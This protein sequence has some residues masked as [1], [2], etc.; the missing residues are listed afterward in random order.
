MNHRLLF[1]K[2]TYRNTF[3]DYAPIGSLHTSLYNQGMTTRLAL[4]LLAILAILSVF[5]FLPF[6]LPIAELD[7]MVDPKTLA[8]PDSQFLKTKGIDIHYK[9]FEVTSENAL[10]SD[11]NF[12]LIHDFATHTFSWREVTDD[13]AALGKTLAYDQPGQGLSD[14]PY[15][16]FP[17][18]NPYTPEA[19]VEILLD[20]LEASNIDKTYL[21][22]SSTGAQIALNTAFQHPDRVKGIIFAGASVYDAGAIRAPARVRPILFSPHM[23]LAGPIIMR[24]QSGD[25]GLNILKFSWAD[26]TK[27]TE[28][29]IAGHQLAQKTSRWN[30]GLWEVSRNSRPSNL[31]AEDL[32]KLDLPILVLSGDKDVVILPEISKQLASELGNGSY[33]ELENCGHL[34]FE[35]CSDASMNAVTTWLA[36]QSSN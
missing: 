14:K 21:V 17:D 20:L 8:S 18:G 27:L 9:E 10:N 13:F 7:G 15:K 34:P 29:I 1:A 23:D 4:N 2:N 31:T 36:S 19:Q 28:E 12:V 6:F 30:Q 16:E 3:G 33:V 5:F 32:A 22:A 26:E 11:V 25:A 24:Q 35:E